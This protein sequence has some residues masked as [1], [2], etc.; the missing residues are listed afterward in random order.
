MRAR[1][2]EH[3]HHH[4]AWLANIVALVVVLVF[5]VYVLV[6]RDAMARSMQVMAARLADVEAQCAAK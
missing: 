4:E 6:E 2:E 5:G 1:K 3:D